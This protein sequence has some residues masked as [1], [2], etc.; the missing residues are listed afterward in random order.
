[1]AEVNYIPPEKK[2]KEPEGKSDD[3]SKILHPTDA[4]FV[5]NVICNVLIFKIGTVF[6]QF[7]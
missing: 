2:S 3:D 1:M 7:Q 6:T 4:S 5:G